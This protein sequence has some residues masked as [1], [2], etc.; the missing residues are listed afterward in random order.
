MK[1]VTQGAECG[2]HVVT[3]PECRTRRSRAG[4]YRLVWISSTM[5]LSRI[6]VGRDEDPRGGL[7][8]TAALGA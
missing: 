3:K 7:L 4:H 2:E 6:T 1:M 8:R 5:E